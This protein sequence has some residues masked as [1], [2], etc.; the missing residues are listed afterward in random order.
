MSKKRSSPKSVEPQIVRVNLACGQTKQEGWIGVDIAKC[1]GVDVVHD[2]NKFPW[3][4]KSDSV[5]EVLVSH[6]VEHIPLDTPKGDGLI[7]FMN[8]LHRILKP[9]GKATILAPYYSSMR[10]WQDPTHRRAISEA[11]FLYFNQGWREQNKLDHYPITANFDYAYGYVMS[12]EWSGRN[13]ELRTFAVRNY[14]N[15]VNDIQ[16]LMTKR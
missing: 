10:C 8:E 6:Y 5:D 7:L 4:F 11:T 16:V 9:G 15:S 1:P 2:L 12:P 3:P 14:V 13:D